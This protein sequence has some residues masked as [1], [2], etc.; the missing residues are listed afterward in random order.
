[1]LEIVTAER[2]LKAMT[3]GRNKPCLIVAVRPDGTQIEVV[4]KFLA[5][6]ER[7][8]RA[9]IAEAIASML[10]ADL[11]LPLPEP[12]LVQIE[13]GFADS[14]PQP[15]YANIARASLGFNFGSAYRSPGYS[16]WNSA[17]HLSEG[18][19]LTAAEIL[20][21]DVLIQNSD[22][23]PLNPNCL[24][25]GNGLIIF[26]HELAFIMEGIIGWKAPWE[27]GGADQAKRHLFFDHLRQKMPS[28][29]RF[30][31]NFTAI[32]DERIEAYGRALRPSPT[33]E[34]YLE[35]G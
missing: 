6:C 26:D 10:A 9:M 5:A 13:A 32:A 16:V 31:T 22:R 14:I 21:F 19:M 29:D 17:N 23:H 33:A 30:Q 18:L 4:V 25:N 27:A 34:P 12:F 2:Y 8:H 3:C 20:S 11:K 15:E 7:G 28:L 1:M 35:H 24:T